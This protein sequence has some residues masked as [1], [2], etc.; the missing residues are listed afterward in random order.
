MLNT[1]I[2]SN[3]FNSYASVS[4]CRQYAE[5]RGLTIPSDD[6]Q[7][8]ILLINALDYLESMYWK[9]EPSDKEQTLSWPRKNIIKDSRKIPSDSIPRQ[10]KDAQ[11]YLAINSQNIEL[12]PINETREV[13]SESIAGALSI[14][15]APDSDNN[16]PTIPY[17][18]RLLRG[19][20]YSSNNVKVSRG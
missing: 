7:L 11:C 18:N 5:S 3:E 8:E 15:Y 12:L 6:S 2:C 13:L 10:I 4:D 9:G 17:I 14:T 1:D 20:C 16:V 19:F